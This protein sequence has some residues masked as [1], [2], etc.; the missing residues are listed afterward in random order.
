MVVK[1]N[2]LD[3]VTSETY[4]WEINPSAGGS[5]AYKKNIATQN[6]V[7]P[8]GK[9][10]LFEGADEPLTLDWTG[11]I[12]SQA[13]HQTFI[14]WWSKRHQIQLTDDLG[15]VF[16]IYITEYTPDRQRAVHY[17]YK[18]SYDM[19]AIVVDWAGE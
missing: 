15:R 12:L 8:G 9:T 3:T 6:T 14:T 19:K 16:M 1:W 18:H 5:P 2:F 4:T 7:A 17:P 11:T 13:Q 10:L